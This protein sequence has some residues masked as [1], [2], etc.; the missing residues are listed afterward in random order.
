MPYKPLI[1]AG[2]IV[3]LVSMGVSYFY[4][5][6]ISNARLSR[7]SKGMGSNEVA[8]ILGKPR[9]VTVG[10]PQA[11]QTNS[12]SRDTFI[13]WVYESSLHLQVIEVHFDP[14]GH[15]TGHWRD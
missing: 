4:G 11:A 7:L 14:T 6:P 5:L 3:T 9:M 8:S 10:D 2:I 15:Y 1:A 12:S 13:T